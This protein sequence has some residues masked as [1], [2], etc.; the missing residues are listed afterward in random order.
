MK[1]LTAFPAQSIVY[2]ALCAC[3]D[4][5][6][7][8]SGNDVLDCFA[9]ASV[10]S[11]YLEDRFPTSGPTVQERID[12]LVGTRRVSGNYGDRG[13]GEAVSGTLTIQYRPDVAS[14]E[15][16]DVVTVCEPD[17]VTLGIQISLTIDD[18]VWQV[19]TTGFGQLWDDQTAFAN[20]MGR[21]QDVVAA[22]G[23]AQSIDGQFFLLITQFP[24]GSVLVSA[25]VDGKERRLTPTDAQ[26]QST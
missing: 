24:D 17:L 8:G 7:F 23:E 18:G 4:G 1:Y 9:T 12:G 2:V 15:R 6:V 25:L 16:F 22:P 13:R 5:G 26:L 10:S 19:E 20:T 21:Y 14:L 11:A 3:G